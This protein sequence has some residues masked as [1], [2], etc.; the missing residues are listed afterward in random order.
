MNKL[1]FKRCALMVS[2]SVSHG[3]KVKPC[4]LKQTEDAVKYISTSGGKAEHRGH[5]RIIQYAPQT[6]GYH[7]SEC[8]ALRMNNCTH[9]MLV[10]TLV[11]KAFT[12]SES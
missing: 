7:R 2:A 10:Q 8:H 9:G 5:G 11:L 3:C 12:A 1:P 6:A 4:H